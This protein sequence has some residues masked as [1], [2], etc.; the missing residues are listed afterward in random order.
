[1]TGA[2]SQHFKEKL[3]SV[4]NNSP[5]AFAELQPNLEDKLRGMRLLARVGQRQ[6]MGAFSIGPEATKLL[7]GFGAKCALALHYRAS[8]KIA[9]ESDRIM[10]I[11]RSNAQH[12]EEGT[13]QQLFDYLPEPASLAQGKF[14]V[15][16][17]IMFSSKYAE[18][19]NISGHYVTFRTLL[20]FL[21][22]GNL[23]PGEI[24]EDKFYRPGFLRS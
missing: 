20:F 22:V 3:R 16:D 15:E 8:G 11:M 18:Y 14:S 6:P 5:K 1:E 4:R 13:P 17:I 23:E 7:E 24:P 10:V 21:F 9:S 19:E 12:L 2:S